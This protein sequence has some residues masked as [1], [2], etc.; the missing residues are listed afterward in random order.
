MI[1]VSGCP[2]TRPAAG[3]AITKAAGKAK[4]I[5]KMV[6]RL[7]LAAPRH[8]LWRLAPPQ[9]RVAVAAVK[10]VRS[11]AKSMERTHGRGFGR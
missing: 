10:L 8:I 2:E 11:L 4:P 9:V 6:A 3:K 5:A 7:Y 1:C